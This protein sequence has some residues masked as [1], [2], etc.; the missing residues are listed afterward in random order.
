MQKW[1]LAIEPDRRQSAKLAMLARN[2]RAEMI[3][4]GSVHEGLD[5]LDERV[6]DLLLISPLLLPKDEALLAERLQELDADGMKVSTLLIPLL[7]TP[8]RKPSGSQKSG[9]GFKPV[10]RGG[11]AQEMCDPIVFAVQLNN[12]L[13]RHAAERPG[14]AA[15]P[16]KRRSVPVLQEVEPEQ[17]EREALEETEIEE[18]E[19]PPPVVAPVPPAVGR[20][21]EWRDLLSAL[22]RDLARMKTENLEPEKPAVVEPP[23]PLV[24]VA[25]ATVPAPTTKPQAPPQP[26]TSSAPAVMRA[27]V[28][29]AP[30]P[31]EVPVTPQSPPAAAQSQSAAAAAAAAPA[32]DPPRRNKQPKNE[33][34]AQ[35]EWGIFDPERCGLAALR[36]KLSEIA[37]TPKKPG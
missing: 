25:R 9:P 18:R 11:R 37:N 26:A 29:A 5:I 3:V 17:V 10:A 33:P 14:P 16:I 15:P 4:V 30:A 27:P 24:H 32:S 6:P 20:T 7:E 13:E 2:Q 1:I 19:A 34:P 8:N 31:A 28:T 23:Q 36:A 22:Q 35:D 21:P 12:Q